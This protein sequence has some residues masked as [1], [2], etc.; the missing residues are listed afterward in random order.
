MGSE[1][2]QPREVPAD[3]EKALPRTWVNDQDYLPKEFFGEL[4]EGNEGIQWRAYEMRRPNSGVE[5]RTE[6]K[7]ASGRV[8]SIKFELGETPN[9]LK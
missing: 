6:C 3:E 2:I 1:V 7:W 8:P 9:L 5:R 4:V